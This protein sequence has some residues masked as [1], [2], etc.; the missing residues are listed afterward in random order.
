MFGDKFVH[1][2][3]QGLNRTF[4]CLIVRFKQLLIFN[5]FVFYLLSG[6]LQIE[7]SDILSHVIESNCLHI[8]ALDCQHLRHN[9]IELVWNCHYVLL[10]VIFLY[11][12][13]DF[14]VAGQLVN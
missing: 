13:G 2:M 8:L 6:L 4:D 9:L 7:I 10:L 14:D 3:L 1:Q 5:Q 12:F 11:I